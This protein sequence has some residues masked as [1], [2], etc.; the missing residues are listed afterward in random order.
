MSVTIQTEAQTGTELNISNSNFVALWS[1]LGL[2][3]GDYYGSI[4]AD[5]FLSL[6]DKLNPKSLVRKDEVEKNFISCGIT[7]EQ[8]TRYY[9]LLRKIALEAKSDEMQVIWL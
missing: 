6:L 8:S 2:E 3:S 9:W 4:D 5:S 1:L 7:L